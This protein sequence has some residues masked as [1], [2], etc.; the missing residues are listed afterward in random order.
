MDIDH[1]Y[2]S[3]LPVKTTHTLTEEELTEAL[4][5]WLE[6]KYDIKPTGDFRI[7]WRAP[8]E[9]KS[10]PAITVNHEQ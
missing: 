10:L 7:T 1:P 5:K 8:Q 9:V 3:A 2:R 6:D 4:L